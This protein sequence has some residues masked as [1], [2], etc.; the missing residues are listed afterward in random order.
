MPIIYWYGPETIE[1]QQCF[2]LVTEMLGPTLHDLFVHCNK[3]FSVSTVAVLAVKLVLESDQIEVIEAVHTKDYLHKNISPDQ[4]CFGV[5]DKSHVLM[6]WNF[7]YAALF[8]DA[9]SKNHIGYNEERI[10]TN[11]NIFTS[12]NVLSGIGRLAA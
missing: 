8:R 1:N 12:V 2:V 5:G 9:F 6:L 4:F 3:D 10:V 11:Y 7:S